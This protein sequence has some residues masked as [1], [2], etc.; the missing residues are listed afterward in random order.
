MKYSAI[1]FDLDGTLVHSIDLYASAMRETFAEAGV[2]LSEAQFRSSYG[3]GLKLKD[4]LVTYGL[5]EASVDTIRTARDK[6]YVKLLREQAEWIRGAEDLLTALKGAHPL[7]LITGSWMSYVDAIDERLSVKPYFRHIVTA[8]HVGD[9]PK[10]HPHG[11]LLA[12]DRLGV[13]PERCLYVGDQLFDVDAAKAA[14]MASCCIRGA[15][16]P[17]EA[18][19]RADVVVENLGDVWKVIG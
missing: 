9:F 4:W 17:S 10:P 3:S 18:L 8:E 1:L 11:L 15:Y 7:G 19:E 14:G 13:E 16:T 12:A 2:D 6:R 5:P